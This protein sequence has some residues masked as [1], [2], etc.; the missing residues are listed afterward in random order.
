VGVW[1]SSLFGSYDFKPGESWDSYDVEQQASMVERWFHN[2][3]QKTDV[4]YPYIRM[5]VRWDSRPSADALNYDRER[6][7]PRVTNRQLPHSRTGAFGAILTPSGFT[8]LCSPT[9]REAWHF[10]ATRN[11]A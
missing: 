4:L 6:P 3:E 10:C 7:A 8:G 2:G 1:V 11:A 9:I 5:V